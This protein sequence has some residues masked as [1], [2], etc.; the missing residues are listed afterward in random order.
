M[1]CVTVCDLGSG[2]RWAV[3]PEEV[4]K[5]AVI[6]SEPYRTL[7]QCE[8]HHADCLNAPLYYFQRIRQPLSL[9]GSHITSRKLLR[10]TR[11]RHTDLLEA[12]SKTV[13]QDGDQIMNAVGAGTQ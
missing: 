5:K 7:A 8:G 9:K 10:T 6:Y 13:R 11:N 4:G 3:A 12:R 1:W 2:P